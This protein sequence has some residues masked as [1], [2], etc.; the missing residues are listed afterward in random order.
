MGYRGSLFLLIGRGQEVEG[1]A[2]ASHREVT[3]K[4]KCQE[5]TAWTFLGW[6]YRD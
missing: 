5:I 3:T 4:K 1:A 6:G 2:Q